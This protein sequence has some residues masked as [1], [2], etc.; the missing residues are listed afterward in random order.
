MTG[1][2]S[3]IPPAPPRYAA[4]VLA[5]GA[6]RRMGGADKPALPVGGRPMLDRVL[7]AVADADPRIVVGPAGDLPAGTL[8]TREQPSGGG[9]VA[10][11]AAGLT[12]LPTGVVA[13]LAADLPLLTP[14]AVRRL[15]T[16]LVRAAEADGVVY[17]DEDGRGQFLCGVWRVAPLRAALT[18]LAAGRDGVLTGT[19]MRALV[20]ELTV[21]TVGW[22]GTGPPP[23]F[24]CDTED[25]VRRAEEWIR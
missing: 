9:P 25:D 8:T 17:V 5:G 20:A 11:L 12:L 2:E 13:L 4:V 15:R 18:R 22:R 7:A 1:L 3:S 19:S 21:G 10:A 16:A 23:W 14:D 6:A 24:D